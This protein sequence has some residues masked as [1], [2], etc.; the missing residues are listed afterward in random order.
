MNRA[1]PFSPAG[2]VCGDGWLARQQ[3]IIEV[4]VLKYSA[5][6]STDN[7]NVSS[8]SKFVNSACM[9]AQYF[10]NLCSFTV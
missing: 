2:S 1:G 3:L 7:E 10:A 6:N 9:F 4:V 5:G 8:D